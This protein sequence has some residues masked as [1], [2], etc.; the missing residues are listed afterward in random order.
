MSAS[1]PARSLLLPLGAMPAQAFGGGSW[2]TPHL[3][4]ISA[5]ALMIAPHSEQNFS[6]AAFCCASVMIL[7]Y[8]LGGPGPNCAPR[9]AGEWKIFFSSA[10]Q[11][12]I[13]DLDLLVGGFLLRFGHDSTLSSRRAEPKLRAA[14]GSVMKIFL[15]SRARRVHP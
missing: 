12:V 14:R 3:G 7:R 15:D 5:F 1:S 8:H 2:R 10:R 13:A 6:S 11:G 9:G 4:Q